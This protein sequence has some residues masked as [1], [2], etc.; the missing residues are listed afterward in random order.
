ME[1]AKHACEVIVIGAGIVGISAAYYLKKLR[2]KCSVVLIDAGQ[3]MALT[4]AQSGEN[5]RNW[6]PH[7]IMG[8]FTDH[9]IDLME[10]I[11]QS[12]GNRINLTR[13]GYVLATRQT[14]LNTLMSELEYG[15][16]QTPSS[17]IREHASASDS[18]EPPIHADWLKAPLGLSLIHI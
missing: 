11:A 15:Y 5:Y 9:S 16:S 17:A 1:A 10:E 8:R 6:W 2:P 4:S 18:Y 14:E 3:A 13:R 12:T 7:P